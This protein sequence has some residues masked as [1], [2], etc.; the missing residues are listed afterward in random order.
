MPADVKT[1]ESTMEV[2]KLF[3]TPCICSP[4][5]RAVEQGVEI[6]CPVDFQLSFKAT[7]TP[8][9]DILPQSSKGTA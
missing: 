9:P 8:L 2:V 6:D 4:G 5:F 1:E 7:S 3:F